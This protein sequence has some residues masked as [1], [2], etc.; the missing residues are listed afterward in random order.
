[1]G[2]CHVE[3]SSGEIRKLSVD[4]DGSQVIYRRLDRL[5]IACHR[6]VCHDCVISVTS[7]TGLDLSLFCPE[8]VRIKACFL[9]GFLAKSTHHIPGFTTAILERPVGRDSIFASDNAPVGS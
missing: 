9:P 5:G 7:H 6:G 2:S 1:M 8:L 3:E 4:D